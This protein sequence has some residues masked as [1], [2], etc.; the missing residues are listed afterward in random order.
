LGILFNSSIENNGVKS[1][2]S[3]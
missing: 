1:A 3:L 2:F